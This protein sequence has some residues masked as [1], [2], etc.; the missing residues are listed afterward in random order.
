MG[1]GF[2]LFAPCFL[3]EDQ[4]ATDPASTTTHARGRQVASL[5]RSVCEEEK[6]QLPDPVMN[7]S[8][9]P[10]SST[11]H[12]GLRY[13]MFSLYSRSGKIFWASWV[14]VSSAKNVD[15]T[16]DISR[17]ESIVNLRRRKFLSKKIGLVSRTK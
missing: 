10:V 16:T 8:E 9:N 14:V 3:V 15:K 1:P 12:S 6:S 17:D 13:A 7:R 5:N 2:V 11:D 4:F